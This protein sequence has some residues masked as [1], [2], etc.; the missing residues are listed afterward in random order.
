MSLDP[1]VPTA[2]M[3]SMDDTRKTLL[4]MLRGNQCFF[5][6][7]AMMPE[8]SR[9]ARQQ[10]ITATASQAVLDR[11]QASLEVDMLLHTLS[12]DTMQ[13]ILAE[14]VAFDFHATR[15]RR[16]QTYSGNHAGA[17]VA[18]LSIR[19]RGGR[20]LT[21]L[22]V[23]QLVHYLQRYVEACEH[24]CDNDGWTGAP[25]EAAH[26]EA[27]RAVDGP[28]MK[29]GKEDPV[30]GNSHTRCDRIRQLADMLR[31]R[32]DPALDPGG[33]VPQKQSPLMVG[34][35]RSIVE[36]VPHHHAMERGPSQTTYTWALVQA[37]IERCLGLPVEVCAIPV[38]VAYDKEHLPLSEILLTTLC[39]SL[40][41]QLGYNVGEQILLNQP[42][43]GENLRK[44]MDLMRDAE[45]MLDAEDTLR[46]L[47]QEDPHTLIREA[48][49]R[50][51]QIDKTESEAKAALAKAAVVD[52]NK[53]YR[54]GLRLEL[55]RRNDML[56]VL[57]ALGQQGDPAE[58]ED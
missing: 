46:A 55:Q 36:R 7:S 22:E 57:G 30:C 52:E 19:G 6:V 2:E 48:E 27:V 4:Y 21:R 26:K 8:L 34:C 32:D 15:P 1:I 10:Q 43:F 13:S 58:E 20:F 51:I 47:L 40:V 39:R 56:T 35:S 11:A 38:I 25:G 31:R 54:D 42:W 45:R 33:N 9:A 49:I 17:Y 12:P 50:L 29:K 44:T 23:A 5:G 41:T 18:A 3:P 53:K 14:T 16:P 24:W 28:W 37:C